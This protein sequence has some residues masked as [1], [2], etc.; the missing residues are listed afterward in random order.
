M[1]A[2][3]FLLS[4]SDLD[5][6]AATIA[7][8]ADLPDDRLNERFAQ[9]LATF[10]AKPRD[11]I[12]QACGSPMA[13]K[14]TYRF[15]SN[16]RFT[17]DDLHRAL[18]AATVENCCGQP[19]V[20]AI[21][22]TTGLS[23]PTLTQTTGLGPLNDSLKARGLLLHTTLA[24]RPDGVPLGVLDQACWGRPEQL[25]AEHHDR[26]ISEKES[27]KWLNGIIAAEAAVDTL[28]APQRP[29]LIHVMDREGDIHEVLQQIDPSRHGAVIR[30]A[31]NRRVE[32]PIGHA[33]DAIASAP[34][35]GVRV[36][37]VPA[38]AGR[39]ARR[40]RLELRAA[41][42]TVRPLRQHAPERTRRPVTWGLVEAREGNAPAGVEPLHWLLWTTEPIATRADLIRVLD[43]YQRRWRIEEFHLALKSGCGVEALELETAERLSRAVALY[44][45]V[46][47]RIVALRDLARH[48][49]D[50]PCTTILSDDAWKVLWLRFMQQRLSADMPPP[51]VRQAILW[52]GRLGGHLGRKRDGLPGVRTLWR[53]WRDLTILVAGLRLARELG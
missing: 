44:S 42:L 10:A 21:Q 31:H 43:I 25:A 16:S 23:Y 40:V 36:I 51:T 47:A 46:A 4:Q 50:T 19:V 48:E 22:D 37:T 34:R 1:T 28:P 8:Q 39:P 30:S 7:A 13:A 52:I 15:L 49:P 27:V 5:A 12:P 45:A 32:G 29:R 14:A 18:G 53:G 11:S 41:T 26:P 20:L 6:W 24:V 38:R 2:Q 35:R 33:H 17:A 9:V 3:S